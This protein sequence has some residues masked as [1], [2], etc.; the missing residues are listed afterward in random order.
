VH[1]IRLPEL[2]LARVSEPRLTDE[3][4]SQLREVL[5]KLIALRQKVG[6][7]EIKGKAEPR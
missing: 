4:F 1:T 2:A 6:E 7:E 3:N 5:A